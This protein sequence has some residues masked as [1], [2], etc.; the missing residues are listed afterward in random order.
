[1]SG[2]VNLLYLSG[3]FFMLEV[4]D[5]VLP[6]RSVPTLVGLAALIAL[7]Y[8]FQGIL[9]FV[10]GRILVRVGASLDESLNTRVY[11]A[12]VDLPLRAG[13]RGNGLQPLH[14]LDNIRAFLSGP[15]PTALFDLPWLPLY[16]VICYLFHPMLGYIAGGGALVL[17]TLTVLTEVL[18]RQPIRQASELGIRRGL[19]ADASRR[20]AEVLRAMGL[21]RRVGARWAEANSRYLASQRRASDVAGGFGSLSK[22]LR[23]MLQSA[24]L[25]TGA[26]LVIKGEATAGVIIASAILTS[27]A[28][29]PVEL[30]IANWRGFLAGRQSWRRLSELL[31]AFPERLSQTPLPKP[32][33]TLRVESASAVPPGSQ[34]LVVQDVSLSLSKG[35]CL[36]VIGPSASGKSSLARLLVGVWQPA[37]G[38]VRIDGAALDQWH[39]EALGRHIGYLP[40]D[41]ELF[42]GSI[43]ENI[44]RFE[45]EPDSDAIIAAATAAGV[46]RMILSLANGYDTEIGE[47]GAVLSSGQRQRIAL[48]RA[49][50]GEPFLVVLDEPNS[51]LDAEGEEAL[52][53]A[54]FGVRQRGGIAVVVAHRRAALAAV[55]TVLVMNG[56]RVQA[57]GPRDEILAK[58]LRRPPLNPPAALKVVGDTHGNQS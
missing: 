30:A 18:T 20:N 25:G 3:S 31:H 41:V 44:A 7:L 28:L 38:K 54:L 6:S 55:D 17:V 53:Q 36:G 49:L 4:Y 22:V 21:G 12:L 23:M 57:L 37:R 10:R 11:Q 13:Q 9:D 26:Y 43:A 5:R 24:V 32:V 34:R 46:H 14:D 19:L 58:V 29:A 1:M 35:Q 45:P 39:P 2:I 15:G 33:E 48:A 56:G 50:Y 40:Q 42:A 52:T 8:S 47:G 51:N 16:L 27:R